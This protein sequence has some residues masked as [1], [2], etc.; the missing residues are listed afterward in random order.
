MIRNDRDPV[1]A[2]HPDINREVGPAEEA[3]A[4][5]EAEDGGR[6]GVLERE[7]AFVSSVPRN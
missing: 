1:P 5:A 2:T 3:E 4:E 7:A 6:S